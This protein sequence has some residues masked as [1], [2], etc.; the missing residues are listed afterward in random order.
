MVKPFKFKLEKI[1]GYREQLEDQAKMALAKA[2]HEYNTQ[3]QAVN[4]IT[5]K[6]ETHIVKGQGSNPDQN[7]IWLWQN[8]KQALEEDLAQAQ[9]RLQE[10]ALNLQNSRQDAVEKSKDRQL[11]DKLKTNQAQKH[12]AQELLKEQKEHDEMATVR[13]EPKD[14]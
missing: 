12:N 10:L 4:A 9:I 3:E 2:Q 13:Y 6:L 8:Y 11:L 14:I 1:L 7:D 5:K